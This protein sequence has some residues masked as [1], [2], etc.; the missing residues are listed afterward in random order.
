MVLVI[1][2]IRYTFYIQLKSLVVHTTYTDY[3]HSL[4]ADK[5]FSTFKKKLVVRNKDLIVSYFFENV[6]KILKINANDIFTKDNSFKP[7]ILRN[8]MSSSLPIR[9][10]MQ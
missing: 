10:K 7:S 6:M 3:S 8:I 9:E 2:C 5:I 4:E 1:L